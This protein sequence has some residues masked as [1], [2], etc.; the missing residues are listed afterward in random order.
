[1]KDDKAEHMMLGLRRIL[2][3]GTLTVDDVHILM[4]VAR[5]AAWAANGD[6]GSSSSPPS[7]VTPADASTRGSGAT[8]PG[9]PVSSSSAAWAARA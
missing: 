1:M 5:Q 2:S 4:G 9:S 3:R 7:K 6:S 8:G